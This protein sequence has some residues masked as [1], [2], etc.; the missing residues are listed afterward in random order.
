M[1]DDKAF[2][3]FNNLK[4]I[5]FLINPHTYTLAGRLLFAIAVSLTVVSISIEIMWW[6]EGGEPGRP[7]ILVLICRDL[8]GGVLVFFL[9]GA[10]LRFAGV[11]LRKDDVRNSS[12]TFSAIQA[13]QTGADNAEQP[14]RM[15]CSTCKEEVEVDD[16]DRCMKCRWP[17]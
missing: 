7:A 1:T 6:A 13:Q 4:G 10:M 3:R 14:N 17:I 15:Y 11:P 8:A 9:G 2:G 12:G 16:D 5:M